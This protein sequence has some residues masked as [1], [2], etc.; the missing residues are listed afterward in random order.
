MA[1]PVAIIII[2]ITQHGMTMRKYHDG[3]PARLR[4]SLSKANCHTPSTHRW[5]VCSVLCQIILFI[6]MIFQFLQW[7]ETTGHFIITQN[8]L[9]F[10]SLIA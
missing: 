8:F 7:F 2:F 6:L 3:Y 9:K 5:P 10:S 1:Q 4:T